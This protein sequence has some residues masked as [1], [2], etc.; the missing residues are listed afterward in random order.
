MKQERKREPGKLEAYREQVIAWSRQGRSHRDISATLARDHGVDVSHRAIGNLLAAVA[1]ARL[2]GQEPPGA[3][4]PGGARVAPSPADV[5]A[6]AAE[7]EDVPDVLGYLVAREAQ[8][9]ALCEH[10][11]PL[12]RSEGSAA[13]I[14]AGLS[15]LQA[16]LA[17]RIDALRPPPAADPETDPDNADARR[18]LLEQ[19]AVTARG[20]RQEY[21]AWLEQAGRGGDR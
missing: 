2:A 14:Y 16:D 13:Q 4:T 10:W 9:R 8:V 15:R 20:I 19:M 11:A 7:A 1:A 12:A 17:K 18:R 3:P 6:L 21:A 5:D